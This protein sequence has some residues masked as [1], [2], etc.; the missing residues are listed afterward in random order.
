MTPATALR[1]E[2]RRRQ[3]GSG[4]ASIAIGTDGLPVI[5]YEAGYRMGLGLLRC[6]DV[7]C[8]GDP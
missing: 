4:L 5:G 2:E 7:L 1:Q 8:S 3:V 6:P